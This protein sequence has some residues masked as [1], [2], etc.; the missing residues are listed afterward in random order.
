MNATIAS[1]TAVHRLSAAQLR[2][3]W[4]EMIDDPLLARIPYKLELNE[5]GSMEVSPA[6]TRHAFLQAF[7]AGELRRLRPEGTT[8][9]ECPIE[10]EIGIRVPDVAWASPEFMS[11]CGMATPLPNA[12]ELCVEILSPSNS[13]AEMNE[14]VAAYLTAGA[15]EVWLVDES[16]NLEIITERGR[17]SA[18]T[19]G[20]GLSLPQ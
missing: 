16:S 10:T 17:E 9:T 15:R 3:R 18:S 6:T 14:K 7:V 13:A 12:P 20:I 1:R 4:L 5:R 2:R 11:R 19:L 8:F